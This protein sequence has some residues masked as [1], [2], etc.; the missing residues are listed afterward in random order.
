[1]CLSTTHEGIWRSEGKHNAFLKMAVFWGVAASSLVETYRCFRSVYCLHHRGNEWDYTAQH[2][3]R[4]LIM[5]AAVRTWNLT[6]LISNLSLSQ[7]P[8]VCWGRG[9]NSTRVMDVSLLCLYV[10][11]SC[12]HTS[13]GVLAC[14]WYVWSQKPRKGALCSKLGTKKKMN[15]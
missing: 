11:L 15:S 5:L 13:R 14:V 4:H 7:W 2:S 6:S 9:F 1:M 3:R 8:L 12:E 10:V